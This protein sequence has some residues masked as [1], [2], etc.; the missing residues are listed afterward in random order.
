MILDYE[1]VKKEYNETS[2][3][4]IE[5]YGDLAYG[6]GHALVLGYRDNGPILSL[7]LQNFHI[8]HAV[9]ARPFEKVQDKSTL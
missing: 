5:Y 7:E 6:K 3:V 9:P 8:T 4:P 1:E 2:R